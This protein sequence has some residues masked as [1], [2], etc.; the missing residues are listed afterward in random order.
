MFTQPWETLRTPWSATDHS[1]EFAGSP[2]DSDFISLTGYFSC[3]TCRPL[4]VVKQI[5]LPLTWTH[6]PRPM[7][8]GTCRTTLPLIFTV[9]TWVRS[10]IVAIR[11]GPMVND[12][13]T[14]C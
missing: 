12:V 4:S 3:T 9:I 1:G 8:T 14:S 5:D 13:L 6:P 10:S 11:D 2:Y 7:L